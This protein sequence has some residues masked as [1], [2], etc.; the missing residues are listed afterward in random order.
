MQHTPP[1]RRL[2]GCGTART[3]QVHP[4]TMHRHA[5][6]PTN[7]HIVVVK[8]TADGKTK[9]FLISGEESKQMWALLQML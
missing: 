2:A 8:T 3:S 4:T 5:E 9:E 7:R 1:A 6:I